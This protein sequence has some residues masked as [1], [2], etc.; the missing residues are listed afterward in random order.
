VAAEELR[1]REQR[2]LDRNDAIAAGAA[3]AAGPE[4]LQHRPEPLAREPEP[5]PPSGNDPVLSLL[6][7]V[8]A[9]QPARS[10]FLKPGDD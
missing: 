5:N 4:R 7:D 10:Q 2:G 3:G 6:R 8:K 1:A 9:F